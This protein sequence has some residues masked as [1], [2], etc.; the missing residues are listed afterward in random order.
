MSGLPRSTVWKLAFNSSQLYVAET[1]VSRTYDQTRWFRACD[2]S[3][4]CRQTLCL[5][6]DRDGVSRYYC[7][8]STPVPAPT[9]PVTALRTL[10]GTFPSALLGYSGGVDS[11]FLAVV[12][13]QELGRERMIAAIG[14][15]AGRRP[16]G[17]GCRRGTHRRRR[18]SRVA[19]FTV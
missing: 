12:L 7:A 19:S 11:A 5:S 13:R 9:H 10:V 4:S 17:L 16:I 18:V 15:S 3:V 14:R 8:M 6:F 1:S 2:L